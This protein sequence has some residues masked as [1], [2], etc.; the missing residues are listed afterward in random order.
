MEFDKSYSIYL[1]A[2]VYLRI[3]IYIVTVSLCLNVGEAEK[4]DFDKS[5]SIYPVAFVCNNEVN[6]LSSPPIHVKIFKTTKRKFA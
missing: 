2:F 1:V 5:Y 3:S 6:Q 4:W